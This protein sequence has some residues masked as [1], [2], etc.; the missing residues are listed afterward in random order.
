MIRL[1]IIVLNIT[2]EVLHEH[3]RYI[4]KENGFNDVSN[5][6]QYVKQENRSA[7]DQLKRFCYN[8]IPNEVGDCDSK[9]VALIQN[10]V[11]E[12]KILKFDEANFTFCKDLRKR[13]NDN[14]GHM[15]I[16]E[17]D[18][19]DFSKT[20][21]RIEEIIRQLCNTDK[22][23]QDFLGKVEDLLGKDSKQI[24]ELIEP[25]AEEMLK[26]IKL[27][28]T[29]KIDRINSRIDK[30]SP[31]DYEIRLV[32]NLPAPT[33][34]IYT[35]I[36][37]AGMFD[38]FVKHWLV[39]IA[40]MSGV[41][42]TT[43]ATKFGYQRKEKSATVR[44][45][46]ADSVTDDYIGL[47]KLLRIEDDKEEHR[48]DSVNSKLTKLTEATQ[49]L[50][51]FDNV[52]DYQIVEKYICYLPEEVSVILTVRNRDQVDND[53]YHCIDLEPF[54]VT[55]SNDYVKVKDQKG[56]QSVANRKNS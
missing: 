22:L 33:S 52:D 38:E 47:A 51:V 9:S 37:E 3:L 50:F 2:T 55:E 44:F 12:L 17:M 27:Y 13:R 40:G 43:H 24:N 34:L 25:L 23:R 41:G 42:K 6:L 46:K 48:I 18:D 4:L 36:E 8:T 28:M 10:I 39:C 19:V 14:Y 56:H 26:E 15:K 49:I 21:V 31:S 16:Y 5:L 7:Y 54:T 11:F 35:R 30:I 20:V 45:F 32:S 53:K 1:S 29:E